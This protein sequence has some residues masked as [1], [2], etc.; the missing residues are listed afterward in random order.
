MKIRPARKGEAKKLQ[1]LNDK[2]FVD[3]SKYDFDL[4]KDWAQSKAGKEYFIGLISNSKAIC[5]IAE[6]NNKPVG[7]IAAAPKEFDW[8]LSK[9]LEIENMGVSPGYRSKGIGSRLIK[10]CMDIAKKRGYQRI[11]LTSYY[12]NK[13]AVAFYEKGGFKKI[14]ISLEK[15]I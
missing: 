5:L 13:K 14:D 11:Y 10:K 12:D 2:V 8:R 4:K 15:D 6:D 9:Y 1:D 7:Y 3:N